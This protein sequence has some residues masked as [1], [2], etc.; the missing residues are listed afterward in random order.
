MQVPNIISTKDLSYLEDIFQWNFNASKKAYHYSNE[1]KIDTIKNATL[2]VA[3]MHAQI[4]HKIIE[5]LGGYNG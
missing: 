5:I 2:D 4:C 1:I 3:K